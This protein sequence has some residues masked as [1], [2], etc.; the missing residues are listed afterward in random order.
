MESLIWRPRIASKENVCAVGLRVLIAL[1]GV[2][3][4]RMFVGK[5]YPCSRG[6]V[7][8]NPPSFRAGVFHGSGAPVILAAVDQRRS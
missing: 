2:S 7:C 5:L 1:Q 3:I 6:L 8:T 4:A